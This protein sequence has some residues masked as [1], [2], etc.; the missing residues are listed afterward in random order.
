MFVDDRLGDGAGR[1]VEP[2][3]QLFLEQSKNGR[4]KLIAFASGRLPSQF[5]KAVPDF[6]RDFSLAP[7]PGIVGESFVS[8]PKQE[9]G[10]PG[11]ERNSLCG[12]KPW[13][14]QKR[15]SGH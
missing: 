15:C 2:L 10:E 3:A 13:F 5:G 8:F 6:P 11:D 4:K 7:K 12:Q 9:E 1:K 14:F